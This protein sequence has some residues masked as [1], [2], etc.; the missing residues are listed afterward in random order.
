MERL[1]KKSQVYWF[2]REVNTLVFS[3]SLCGVDIIG[4]STTLIQAEIPQ[5][6]ARLPKI[7]SST[8][9]SHFPK[10]WFGTK[11]G[12]DHHDL[13]GLSTSLST[14]SR[15]F[16]WNVMTA[17]TMI[18]MTFST[19]FHATLRMKCNNFSE[20]LTSHSPALSFAL[21]TTAFCSYCQL[22]NVN[23]MTD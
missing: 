19:H 9:R 13:S 21:A 22:A 17:I 14:I 23:I 2:E 4:W 1:L 15:Q 5:L 20:P 12:A 10:G 11:V 8:S 3:P 18:A 7:S 16:G 6:L